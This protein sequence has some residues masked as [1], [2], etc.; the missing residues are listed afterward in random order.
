[1]FGLHDG[2][3]TTVTLR[4]LPLLA[5]SHYVGL[6][7]KRLQLPQIT[8]YLLT[9]VLGGPHGL[10]LLSNEATRCA[11]RACERLCPLWRTC[12][13]AA[14]LRSRLWPVDNLCLAVIGIAAGCELHLVELRRKEF[15]ATVLSLTAAVT[16]TT[17]AFV[18]PVVLLLGPHI[19]FLRGAPRGRLLS[20]ASLAATLGVARSPA[21]MIAVLREMDARGPFCSLMMS[22]TVVKDV[23]VL[24]LFSVNVEVVQA[25]E[26]AASGFSGVPMLAA[27][28][29]ATPALK[30]AVSALLGAAGGMLLGALLVQPRV[31]D[32][33]ALPAAVLLL[34]AVLF[35]GARALPAEP[36]LV[37][38]TA[39]ALAA[40][41][42]EE[43]GERQREELHGLLGHLMPWVNLTFFTLAGAALA[44]DALAATAPV[45]AV[46]HAV[47]LLSL[48]VATA[49]G[50]AFGLPR[51]MRRVAWM[52]MV[53]QAGVALGLART[54]LARFPAWGGDFYALMVATIVLNQAV[55]PP[56]FR[57]AVVAVGEH[58]KRSG[59]VLPIAV[60]ASAAAVAQAPPAAADEHGDEQ[61]D[62]AA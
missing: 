53:T 52:A 59:S 27:R 47:R 5:V 57:A 14:A 54:V 24:L 6:L 58:H 38:V 31:G 10:H 21:S 55:G 41:R 44:V 33:G 16:A 46:I 12:V 17:W 42:R 34:A 19:G 45:A 32:R 28:C 61:H 26:A 36:L 39:G 20:V 62:R 35:L 48:V 4:T 40:N 8:G 56:L 13:N 18:F 51:E 30:L 60:A 22:V 9:G 15:R 3:L 25:V 1:M 50:D 2:A 29:I 7:C 11:T 37:C 23:L 43:R 49:G